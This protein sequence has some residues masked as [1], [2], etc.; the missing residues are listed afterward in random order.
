M[1]TEASDEQL[2]HRTLAG[3]QDAFA[4]L[5]R[6]H[7]RAALA[8]ALAVL[9]NPADA[10]DIAQEA[11]VHAYEQLATCRQPDRFAAWLMTIVHRRALNGLRSSKRRRLAP[12]DDTIEAEQSD[13]P[14]RELERADLRAQLLAAL[15]RLA[16]VQREIV[17][18]ADVEH[19]SHERIAAA[20]GVSVLMSRRHLSDARRRLRTLLTGATD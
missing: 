15:A 16:P 1:A 2:V 19:W 18:L 17:L 6:R 20:T 7:R 9:G 12:L 13:A 8:R 5:V 14:V 11:F 4:V 3:E 10:D